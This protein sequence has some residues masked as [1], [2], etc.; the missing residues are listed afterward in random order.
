MLYLQFN[1]KN[2][3][4]DWNSKDINRKSIL[5]RDFYNER[6]HKRIEE[7]G[8]W[9]WDWNEETKSS[10]L[11]QNQMDNLKYYQEESK[12]NYTYDETE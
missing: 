10:P 1:N 5:I 2:S 8:Q 11:F 12:L 7:L 3:T 9:D 6:I 4:V